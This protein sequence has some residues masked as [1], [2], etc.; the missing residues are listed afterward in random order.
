M[1]VC[2]E[3]LKGSMPRVVLRWN[4]THIS[5][6]TAMAAGLDLEQWN[7]LSGLGEENHP[8]ESP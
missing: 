7:M 3:N 1:R 5:Q 6:Q 4:R 2:G 8:C